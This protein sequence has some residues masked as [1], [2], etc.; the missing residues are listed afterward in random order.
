MPR[1]Q[2]DT[3]PLV[4]IIIPSFNDG[5]VV[6]DA[7]NCSLNQTYGN[8]EI[9]V[10]DDGSTDGTR[11]ML[12]KR[13]GNRI[14]CIR[15]SNRGLAGARNTGIRHAAGRYLQFLDSD[16]L[17]DPDKISIQMQ[18]MLEISE[19]ALSYSDYVCHCIH[20]PSR[21]MGC[22]SPLLGQ[23]PF[24]DIMMKWESELSIPVHCYLFD[25]SLFRKNNIRFDENLQNHEDWE[26]WMNIFALQ[27][28][29]VF[30][31]RK[32]VSYR[33]RGDSLCR[34]RLKMRQGYLAAID[35]QLN[36][37]RSNKEVS[38]KLRCR[39][40]QVRFLYRDAGL[41]MRVFDRLPGILK[42]AYLEQVPWRLQ[43]MLD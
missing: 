35:K 10:V 43:R 3:L 13:Y 14:R 26:C 38:S 41:V 27:P 6:C 2:V 9:I 15:Q 17:L 37:Y 24:D 4:S 23:N 33:V 16:D 30:D 11:Q 20:D 31:N 39:K 32:L 18:K 8:I 29:I 21:L 42:N 25:A 1:S 19:P 40:K 12:E 22:L 7:V 34:D 36:K 5:E 28:R